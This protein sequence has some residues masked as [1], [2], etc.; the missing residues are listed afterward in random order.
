MESQ[1]SLKALTTMPVRLHRKLNCSCGMVLLEWAEVKTAMALRV[2]GP[3]WKSFMFSWR[4][5]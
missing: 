5:S 2:R 1:T 4:S 3:K